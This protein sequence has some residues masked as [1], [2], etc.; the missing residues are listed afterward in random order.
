MIEEILLDYLTAA[1]D[2]P[3]FLEIPENMPERFIVLEK[4]GSG[5][6]NHIFFATM[7]VQSYAESLYEAAKL[8]ETVK[9][10]LL[11]GSTPGEIC[12]VRL[13]S[14]YNFTDP[15]LDRYRYQAVYDITHYY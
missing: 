7:A 2:V 8:N 3:V 4:T 6:E 10:A 9:G 12:S 15:D 14:D 1:A 11:Y 13:N 5:C